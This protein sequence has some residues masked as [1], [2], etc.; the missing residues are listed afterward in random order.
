MDRIWSTSRISRSGCSRRRRPS[1][2]PLARSGASRGVAT[3]ESH[4][5]P[6][7]VAP[8]SSRLACCSSFNTRAFCICGASRHRRRR[9]PRR[10]RLQLCRG[11]EREGERRACER[12]ERASERARDWNHFSKRKLTRAID[13]HTSDA[14]LLSHDNHRALADRTIT[15]LSTPPTTLQG[16]AAVQRAQTARA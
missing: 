10:R 12:C 2:A 5:V 16:R 11:C 6:H 4:A 8:F 3:C 1:S 7:R 14:S 9:L 15:T 13:S